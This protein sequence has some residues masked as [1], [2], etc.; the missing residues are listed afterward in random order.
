MKKHVN[1]SLLLLTLS[2]PFEIRH[3]RVSIIF[4]TPWRHAKQSFSTSLPLFL[5]FICLSVCLVG[6]WFSFRFVSLQIR[7]LICSKFSKVWTRIHLLRSTQLW[8]YT[9]IKTHKTWKCVKCRCEKLSKTAHCSFKKSTNK[10]KRI[11]LYL[12]DKR[13]KKDNDRINDPLRRSLSHRN[14]SRKYET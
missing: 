1:K 7:L 8:I 10:Q 6:F 2:F 11:S 3:A 14:Y 4:H 13:K 5:C 12:Q 9:L